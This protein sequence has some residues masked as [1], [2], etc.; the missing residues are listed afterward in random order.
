MLRFAV[1]MAS[2][3]ISSRVR[4]ARSTYR[5]YIRDNRCV[6]YVSVFW[7]VCLLVEQEVKAEVLLY[8]SLFWGHADGDGKHQAVDTIGDVL[9]TSAR[10]GLPDYAALCS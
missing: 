10:S 3:Y 6:R 4:C 9:N 1:A 5:Q 8:C 7:Q 2:K